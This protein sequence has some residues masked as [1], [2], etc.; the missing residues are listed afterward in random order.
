[1]SFQLSREPSLPIAF[2]L[3]ISKRERLPNSLQTRAILGL[4]VASAFVS[5]SK[6]EGINQM[7]KRALAKLI[8]CD[9]SYL[10]TAAVRRILRA[11]T[12]TN[13]AQNDTLFQPAP[14]TPCGSYGRCGGDCLLS[15]GARGARQHGP[16]AGPAAGRQGIA[17][18]SDPEQGRP[19]V[20][21]RAADRQ[22]DRGSPRGY[23]LRQPAR[24]WGPLSKFYNSW[25]AERA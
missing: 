18:R 6:A 12:S 9:K 16:R 8:T 13:G 21:R 3:E 1:M 11:V 19:Q 25:S 22:G 7:V 4:N 15:G 20:P 17:A 14:R 23:P 5:A 10:P 24:R 2:N